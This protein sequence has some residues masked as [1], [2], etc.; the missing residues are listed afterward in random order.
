MNQQY[1]NF[2]GGQTPPVYP[3]QP[4]ASQQGYYYHPCYNNPFGVNPQVYAFEQQKKAHQKGLTKKANWVGAAMLFVQL[5]GIVLVFLI[6]AVVDS[7]LPGASENGGIFYEAL[8]YAVYSPVSIL[9]CFLVV[10]K[11]SRHSLT[12]LIPFEKHSKGLGT[13]CILF[14]FFGVAVGNYI[15]GIVG[16]MFPTIEE[17]L[18]VAMGSDPTTPIELLLSILYVAAIPALVEEFAFRG[19]AMGML[20]TYG[21]R[22]ALITSSLLFALL[23]G[24]FIQIPFAFCVGLGLGYAVLRTGSMLPAILIHFFNNAFSCLITYWEEALENHFGAIATYGIYALW[25]LMGIVGLLI[26]KLKYKE[27][28]TACLKP[29]EGCLS[30]GGRLGAFYCSVPIILTLIV[31]LGTSVLMAF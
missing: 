9:L 22:F 11:I 2:Q 13:G 31:Y 29:Y 21:D 4:S 6:P 30:V 27:K 8:E 25:I 12:D 16:W 7:L 23:H 24:N 26:L 5:L 19:V 28:L 15:A 3:N 17:N 18:E 20:R 10:A 14:A 1:P